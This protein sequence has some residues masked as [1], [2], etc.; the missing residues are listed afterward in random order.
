MR[1]LP[2][3]GS[4]SEGRAALPAQPENPRSQARRP[5]IL[6]WPKACTTWPISMSKWAD[7]SQCQAALPAKLENL[8]GQAGRRSSQRGRHAAKIWRSLHAASQQFT[9]ARD[10]FD[11]SRHVVRRVV[12][13]VL[14][15]LSEREQIDFLDNKDR[16]DFHAA[17][18]ARLDPP[19]R[20]SH[21]RGQRCQLAGQRQG[22]SAPG[23]ACRASGTLLAARQ[24]R[25]TTAADRQRAGWPKSAPQLANLANSHP[26]SGRGSGSAGRT[27]QIEL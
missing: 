6:P 7:L 23:I 16:E 5:I 26:K 21:R 25:S 1:P 2:R 9:A 24:Q 20:R 17:L 19:R 12:A 4:V 18:F 11:R 27:G 14:P 15:M 10:D 13:A 22:R 8:G 3:H